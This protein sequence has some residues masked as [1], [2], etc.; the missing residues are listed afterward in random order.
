[1]IQPAANM[2]PYIYICSYVMSKLTFCLFSRKTKI[3]LIGQ[4]SVFMEGKRKPAQNFL[5]YFS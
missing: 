5:I 1:M 4:L 2:K 3:L